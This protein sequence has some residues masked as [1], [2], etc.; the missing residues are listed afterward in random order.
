MGRRETERVR[1]DFA[2]EH[3]IEGRMSSNSP[4]KE[5]GVKD[6][7]ENAGEG[8]WRKKKWKMKGKSKSVEGSEP[9]RIRGRLTHSSV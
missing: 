2:N 6:V 8:D 3:R 1:E 5:H 9:T 7:E 4:K